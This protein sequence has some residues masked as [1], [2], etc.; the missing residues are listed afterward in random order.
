MSIVKDFSLIGES[1]VVVLNSDY[2]EWIK[3]HKPSELGSKIVGYKWMVDNQHIQVFI[4]TDFATWHELP[5]SSG[6]IC[7]E[8]PWVPN[9]CL[10][11]DAYGKERIRLTVPWQLTKP[12]NPKSANPP[13]SF[14]L[15]SAPYTNPADG[16]PGQFG[17]TAWVEHAGMHYF[18]L[19]YHNGQFLWG[20]E[21]RD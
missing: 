1:G 11:L 4:N 3:T 5:D 18:E 21:I 14:A 15:P 17:I 20:R 19:N 12:Q 13:T 16:S 9:N 10:L 2:L 6:F 7:F 8:K